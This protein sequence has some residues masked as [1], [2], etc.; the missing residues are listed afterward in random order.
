MVQ[1]KEI[2]MTYLVVVVCFCVLG[3]FGAFQAIFPTV[4]TKKSLETP[5]IRIPNHVPSLGRL[6]QKFCICLRMY[7][8]PPWQCQ[9]VTSVS[10]VCHKCVTSVSHVCH[11]CVTC[12]CRVVN[13]SVLFT[14]HKCVTS[15]SQVCHMCVTCVSH[16]VVES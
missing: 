7:P 3:V 1:N 10:Q 4:K 13:G 15:V 8:T 12:C 9:H 11:M 6:C 16:V 5:Q 2:K 14:C